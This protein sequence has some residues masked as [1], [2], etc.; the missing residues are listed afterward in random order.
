M[1]YLFFILLFSCSFAQAE[2]IL[3]IGDSHS[4]G[5]FGSKLDSLLRTKP[6]AVVASYAS[7]GSTAAW[8]YNGKFTSCG[9]FEG[10]VDGSLAYFDKHATPK[11]LDLFEKHHPTLT[12]VALGTNYGLSMGNSGLEA[13]AVAEMKKLANDIEHAGSKCVWITHPKTRRFASAEKKL[14]TLIQSAVSS[15]CTIINSMEFTDYPAECPDGLHYNCKVGI[16][17]AKSWAE[18]VFLKI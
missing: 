18:K 16:P 17:M 14:L 3:F 11:I 2:R 10:K 12:I 13:A 7:C 8:F 4:V 9:A 1:K 15:K 6:D 5:A